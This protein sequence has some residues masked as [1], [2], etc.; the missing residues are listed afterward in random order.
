MPEICIYGRRDGCWCAALR[1]SPGSPPCWWSDWFSS[2]DLVIARARSE[3]RT[4]WPDAADAGLFVGLW[5]P[6]ASA[7]A[8]ARFPDDDP[9]L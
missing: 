1:P 5:G 2:L 9:K 4:R 6:A 7:K 8:K 3:A